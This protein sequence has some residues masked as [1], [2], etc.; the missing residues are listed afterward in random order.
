MSVDNQKLIQAARLAMHKANV[1]NG[2]ASK[3]AKL[4]FERVC[5]QVQLLV[6]DLR[7]EGFDIATPEG[8]VMFDLVLAQKLAK[9]A[10]S[11]GGDRDFDLDGWPD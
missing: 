6:D 7:S 5:A 10:N 3:R 11:A 8:K 2:I 9:F 1:A 4:D